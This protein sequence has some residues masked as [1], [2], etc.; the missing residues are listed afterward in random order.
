MRDIR[1]DIRSEQMGLFRK[2]KVSSY[3][4]WSHKFICLDRR[5]ADRVPTT[6]SA[7]MLLEEAGLGEKTV[8]IP[9]IDCDPEDFHSLILSA[10]PKL[11]DGG[12]F[13]LLRCKPN[14]RDLLVIGP[15]VSS[16]PKLLK[17]RIGNGKVYIRPVQRDLSL[18][19][20]ED[21]E[22]VKGVSIS[23]ASCYRTSSCILNLPATIRIV[24]PH[25]QVAQK[26]LDCG[27][28]CDNISKLKEHLKTCIG[29]PSE[30]CR[31]PIGDV[32]NCQK[33]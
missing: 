16:Y 19:A 26:C 15:R 13:E 31:S 18:E 6:Q 23:L 27:V 7:K 2:K 17:R 3:V 11:R 8:V 14:L 25:V 30:R 12:G 4:S 28:L 22:E 21:C 1:Q 10:Y 5:D 33:S 24:L 9:D 29:G 32:S 20:D